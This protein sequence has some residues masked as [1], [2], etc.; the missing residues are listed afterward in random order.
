MPV[1]SILSSFFWK[2][3]VGK[4][5]RKVSGSKHTALAALKESKLCFNYYYI[6]IHLSIPSYRIFKE[7]FWAD[8]L[9]WLTMQITISMTSCDIQWLLA[10]LNLWR[11]LEYPE[12]LIIHNIITDTLCSQKYLNTGLFDTRADAWSTHLQCYSCTPLE[13][14]NKPKP[15]PAWWWSC[16]APWPHGVLRLRL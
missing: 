3:D 11:K 15:V 1:L 13:I 5:H 7:C 4:R 12:A 9:T 10:F 8:T 2:I 6:H 16:A 14:T